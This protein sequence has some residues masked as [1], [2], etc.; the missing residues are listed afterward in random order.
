MATDAE[1]FAEA[2]H[3]L[4]DTFVAARSEISDANVKAVVDATYHGGWRGFVADSRANHG[5]ER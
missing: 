5:G 3:W 4:D 1:L 2:R